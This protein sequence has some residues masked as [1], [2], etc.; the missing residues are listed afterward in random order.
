MAT[1]EWHPADMACKSP[2][3]V[4]ASENPKWV[5]T[6]GVGIDYEPSPGISKTWGC[7][8]TQI[9]GGQEQTPSC[10]GCSAEWSGE[11]SNMQVMQSQLKREHL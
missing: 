5:L 11:N 10:Q 8:S 1:K 2:L 6:S 4:E 9:L 7:C 3:L